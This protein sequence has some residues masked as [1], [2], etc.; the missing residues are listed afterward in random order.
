VFLEMGDEEED[1]EDEAEEGLVSLRERLGER[2]LVLRN[3]RDIED[4][5]DELSDALGPLFG[6]PKDATRGG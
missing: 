4:V 5:Y 2:A 1:E 6:A 3:D